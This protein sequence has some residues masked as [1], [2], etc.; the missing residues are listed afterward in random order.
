[1]K[2]NRGLQQN[3]AQIGENHI[4][5]TANGN[6]PQQTDNNG[7]PELSLIFPKHGRRNNGAQKNVNGVGDM[8]ISQGMAVPSA[9][10]HGE[11]KSKGRRHTHRRIRKVMD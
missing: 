5:Q 4:T 1:M 8:K 6:N 7:L 10:F 2:H 3:A 9:L 11:Q